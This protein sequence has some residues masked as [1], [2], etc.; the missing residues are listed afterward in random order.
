MDLGT[1]LA[2]LATG[3]HAKLIKATDGR[4]A[5]E[6]KGRPM[7]VLATT[8]RKTGKRR[9]RPLVKLEID[10]TPH[11]IASNNGAD[12]HPGWYLNLLADPV[13]HVIDGDESYD[14][15]AVPLEGDE[16][17]AAYERAKRLMANF[18]R[19]ERTASRTIPVIRLER[20]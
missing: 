6:F 3:F 20:A 12:D 19:Y 1:R 14:A 9:E 7:V 5:G 2:A 10:G 16:R 4:V 17:T 8:G 15:V 11:V 13:V 18:V